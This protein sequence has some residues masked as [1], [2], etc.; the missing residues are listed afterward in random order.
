MFLF[1]QD[2]TAAHTF[3]SLVARVP[4]DKAGFLSRYGRF[5]NEISVEEFTGALRD[6]N[7]AAGE[8]GSPE[9]LKRRLATDGEYLLRP[10]PP[11]EVYAGIVWIS[12]QAGNV[13]H[14]IS[15]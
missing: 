3:F 13:A 8:L 7:V 6:V 10:N 12:M 1:R 9:S 4:A 15:S 2:W 11:D 14:T 5:E